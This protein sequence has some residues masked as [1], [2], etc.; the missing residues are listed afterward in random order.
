MQKM[1]DEG[2]DLQCALPILSTYLGHNNVSSTERYLRMTEEMHGK[3]LS[4]VHQ[5]YGDIVPC[6]GK[7]V[8]F[9]N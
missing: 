3:L 1:A 6:A 8:R 7:E 9:E 4:Q 5:M 2:M